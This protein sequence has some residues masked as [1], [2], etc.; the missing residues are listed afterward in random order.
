[1]RHAPLP[2]PAGDTSRFTDAYPVADIDPVDGWVLCGID[3]LGGREGFWVEY[4][5]RGPDRDVHLDVS[6]WRWTPSNE[7]F[8]WLVRN[9]FPPR[10]SLIA[11]WDD[12]DI[13]ARIASGGRLA[14]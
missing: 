4:I 3:M 11:P 8:A 9:G 7:R 14:A 12:F 6:R 2:A 5:A 13:E 1:M 10:P